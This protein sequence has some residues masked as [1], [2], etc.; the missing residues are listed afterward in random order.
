MRPEPIYILDVPSV[1]FMNDS[2]PPVFRWKDY[3]MIFGTGF[4]PGEIV[5]V[6]FDTT[7]AIYGHSD[8]SVNQ[9][10]EFSIPVKLPWLRD[11]MYRIRAVGDQGTLAIAD[12]AFRA[13]RTLNYE[14]EDLKVLIAE[15]FTESS[16]LGYFAYTEWSNQYARLLYPDGE[17]KRIMLA[18]YVPVTDTFHV[19]LF[20]T[21]GS[22]YGNYD[23]LLDG[24]K[25]T[26]FYG[27]IDT[28]WQI[29]LRS[30]ELD[31]GTYF[32]T[33]GDHTITYLCTGKDPKGL[34]YLLNADNLILTPTTAFHPI[35]P[36]TDLSVPP[37]EALKYCFIF[38]YRSK[39]TIG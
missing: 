8:R 13:T 32:L 30:K 21:I 36:D 7:E 10:Y 12:V 25:S 22:R 38:F 15:G 2:I 35:P 33:R 20:N 27:F 6:F 11:G 17:G 9:Q 37:I 4:K 39:S 5:S 34:D 31:G 23:I 28:N 26:S 3:I 14:C 16:Y 29:P 1:R 24:E 18:F 19:S